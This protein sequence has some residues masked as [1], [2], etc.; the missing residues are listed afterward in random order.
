MQFALGGSF[1]VFAYFI[2]QFAVLDGVIAVVLTDK[3][4]DFLKLIVY[5]LPIA[6]Y[7]TAFVLV[8]KSLQK[9]GK[10]AK[11]I[12][13]LTWIGTKLVSLSKAN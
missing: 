7:F 3:K 1:L 4:V 9:S 6:A 2:L 12:K 11:K 10:W 13:R 8:V 5:V